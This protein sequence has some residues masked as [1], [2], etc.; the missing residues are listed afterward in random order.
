MTDVKL[1]LDASNVGALLAFPV[2]I[3]DFDYY[4]QKH[5]IEIHLGFYE[6]LLAL[7]S[8]PILP[9]KDIEICN[10]CLS[11]MESGMLQKELFMLA[12]RIFLKNVVGRNI[13]LRKY[14]LKYER[15]V[16]PRL[17]LPNYIRKDMDEFR[18]FDLNIDKNMKYEVLSL[19]SK[20]IIDANDLGRLNELTSE[21]DRQILMDLLSDDYF[22]P[23]YFKD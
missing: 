14:K 2:H 1:R 21:L 18:V 4:I 9:Q 23:Y 15:I 12:Y 6:F 3:K 10:R 16:I 22:R 7:N 17:V 19:F 8:C 5:E 20:G 11:Q 13:S